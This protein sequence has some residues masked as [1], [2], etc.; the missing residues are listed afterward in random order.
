[1]AGRAAALLFQ[2][3]QGKVLDPGGA[4][5]SFGRLDRFSLNIGALN[6]RTGHQE[7]RLTY[8]INDRFFAIGELGANGDFGGQI[9]YLIRFR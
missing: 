2:E 1:M 6:N 5:E 4:R 7:T 8:Q 9:K 3:L